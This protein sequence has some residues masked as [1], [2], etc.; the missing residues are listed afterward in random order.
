MFRRRFILHGQT[1]LMPF[2]LTI[3]FFFGFVY[4]VRYHEFAILFLSVS[5]PLLAVC[6]GRACRF[7]PLPDADFTGE[8]TRK[9]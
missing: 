2:L 6:I 1:Q 5:L 3:G 8:K 4:I 9:I 7:R